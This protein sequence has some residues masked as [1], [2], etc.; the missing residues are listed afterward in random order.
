MKIR[1]KMTMEQGYILHNIN[2]CVPLCESMPFFPHEFVK[3]AG[4]LICVATF[5][6][7]QLHLDPIPI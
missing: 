6:T 3:V 7:V 1:N 4:E 5:H 2:K